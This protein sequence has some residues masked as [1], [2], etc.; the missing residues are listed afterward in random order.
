MQ[1]NRVSGL[2]AIERIVRSS[3]EFYAEL[4]KAENIRKNIEGL[5]KKLPVI[6]LPT[7]DS[8]K[9]PVESLLKGLNGTVAQF[10]EKQKKIDYHAIVNSFLPPGAE[11]IRPQ[12][13]E[14][15]NEIQFADLDADGRNELVTSY[16]TREG[17]RTLILKKDDVQWYRM[18]EISNPEFKGMHYRNAANIAGDGRQYLLLGLN[19][20]LQ[21]KMLF[22]YSLAD[23][24]AK[25]IFGRKYNMLE[26]LRSRSTKEPSKDTLALWNEEAPN[27]YDIET[28]CWNGVEI[29]Q[30]DNKRY[31]A[32][33]VVP[34]YIRKL[35]QNPN[36]T[37][38][39]Y[40]LANVM[41]KSGNTANAA[42]AVRLGLEHNPDAFLADKFNSLK[43]R[44]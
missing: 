14:N 34:Y 21:S 7:L 10:S 33:K 35:R 29:M 24:N 6:E 3:L 28:V 22:A 5:S 40:N 19:S 16:K 17:I 20:D 1:T 9:R 39:W 37:V 41:A 8:L 15:S 25:K 4:F 42:E 32:D 13:P 38:G 2:E 31:L 26:L 18:A 30:L 27:I 43:N 11:L 12:Y 23:G 36:D 44:L